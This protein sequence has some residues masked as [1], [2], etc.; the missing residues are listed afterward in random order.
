M[1]LPFGLKT[2]LTAK[3]SVTF[4]SGDKQETVEFGARCLAHAIVYQMNGKPVKT[5]EVPEA[6]KEQLIGTMLAGVGAGVEAELEAP[7][8]P[9]APQLNGA[10]PTSIIVDEAANL[11]PETVKAIE[12][13]ITGG[14]QIEVHTTHTDENP[15]YQPEPVD[16]EALR[17]AQEIE[18]QVNQAPA[19]Y[20]KSV[21]EDAPLEDNL[22]FDDVQAPVIDYEELLADAEARSVDNANLK[23]LVDALYRRFNVYLPFVNQPPRR[24]DI[25]PINGMVMNALTYGQAVQGFKTAQRAGTSWNPVEIRAQL[26]SSR[27]S[28]SVVEEMPR[29]PEEAVQE[30]QPYGAPLEGMPEN[31]HGEPAAPAMPEMPLEYRKFASPHKSAQQSERGNERDG[32]DPDEVY[33]EPPINAQTAIIRPFQVNRRSMAKLEEIDRQRRASIPQNISFNDLG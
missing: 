26:N 5:A 14:T 17:V 15:F 31:L 23:V 19:P 27:A 12:P 24:S 13:I 32:L 16:H 21:L 25:S 8:E 33:A 20:G 30:V 2:G 1:A 18:A 9:Q 11:D 4:D 7:A 28:S 29:L 22:G 3:T 6:V 10:E